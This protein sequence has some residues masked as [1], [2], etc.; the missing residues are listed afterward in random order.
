MSRADLL[1][2]SREHERT[3]L[4][5]HVDGRVQRCLDNPGAADLAWQMR[6][7]A[8]RMSLETLADAEVAT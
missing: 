1:A 2:K 5:L 6:D 7:I 4:R 3:A 8:R